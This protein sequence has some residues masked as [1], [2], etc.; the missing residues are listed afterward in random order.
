MHLIAVLTLAAAWSIPFEFAGDE[1]FVPVRVNGSTP[2]WFAVDSAASSLILAS[3]VARRFGF[4]GEQGHGR[5]AGAGVVAHTKIAPAVLLQIGSMPAAGYSMIA[6]DLSGPAKNA[7][8]TIDGLIGYEFFSRYVVEIDYEHHRMTMTAPDG[9]RAPR[10]AV[11]L[12]L[13]IDHKLPFVEAEL[14][15][16][17]VAPAK[18]RFLIDTG[19]GDGVDHPLIKQSTGEVRKTITGVGLGTPIEGYVGRAEYFKLGPYVVKEPALACC[20]G[21]EFNQQ[22][23][24]TAI[25]EH[26]HL[27]FDYP[28]SRLYVRKR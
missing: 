26:F 14:K 8:H 12:P 9:F 23:I 22:M 27:T 21:N 11:A 6:I 3:A 5:G 13:V 4:S 19:S 1:I 7:G 25:L 16:P 10:N 17:G 2:L 28:H 24:G 18:G 15:V 20:G